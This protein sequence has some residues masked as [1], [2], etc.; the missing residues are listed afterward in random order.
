M[1]ILKV[2][3]GLLPKK[4]KEMVNPSINLCNKNTAAEKTKITVFEGLVIH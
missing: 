2:T 3:K 4:L 1:I